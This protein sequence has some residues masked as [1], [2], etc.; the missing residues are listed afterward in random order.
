MTKEEIQIQE[1]LGIIKRYK[2][3]IYHDENTPKLYGLV[4][5]GWSRHIYKIVTVL[6]YSCEDACRFVAIEYKV[7][8]MIDH[9]IMANQ[10]N[11][12]PFPKFC[13]L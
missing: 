3:T 10:Y 2:V 8:D 5:R 9:G 13:I 7:K 4:Y 6:S 12:E 11:G 1:A